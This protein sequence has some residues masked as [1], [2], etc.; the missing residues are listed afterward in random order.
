MKN[1]CVRL[2]C[3][4]LAAGMLTTVSFAAE[5]AWDGTA[6]TTWYND[7]DAEFIL[8]TEEQLAGLNELIAQGNTFAGKTVKL[9]ADMD[10]AGHDWVVASKDFSG[11]FDGQNH[12]ISHICREDTSYTGGRLGLFAHVENGTVK[13]LTVDGAEFYGYGPYGGVIAGSA[14]G[15]C[16]FENITLKNCRNEM[17]NT[18]SAGIVGL[19]YYDSDYTFRGISIDET[20]TIGSFWGSWDTPSGGLIGYYWANSDVESTILAEDCLIAPV[21]NVYNDVCANYQWYA[22]RYA[23][24]LIGYVQSTQVVDGTT[25]PS[26]SNL[27]CRNVTVR[28]GGWS[29]YRYCEWERNGKASYSQDYKFSR[30]DNNDFDSHVHTEEE[31][32]HNI[33]LP[34]AQLFG[35]T[36][37]VYGRADY[38][39]VTIAISEEL[40]EAKLDGVYYK[41]LEETLAAAGDG[42]E[43]ELVKDIFLSEE[44]SGCVYIPAEKSL[45]LQMNNHTIAHEQEN[46]NTRIILNDGTLHIQNGTLNGDIHSSGH[47]TLTGVTGNCVACEAGTVVIEGGAFSG[48]LSGEGLEIRGGEFAQDPSAFV[49][50]GYQVCTISHEIYSY[51]VKATPASPSGGSSGI[52]NN[53]TEEESQW[54]QET[55]PVSVFADV[56]SHVY[57]ADAVQWAAEEKI[58]DGTSNTTFSPDFH[59]TRAQV[60]TFLWRAAGC[61]VPVG[62][63]IPFADVMEDAY[64]YDAVVWALEEGITDG[65]SNAT[66]SPDAHCT[67]AQIVTFLMRAQ[68]AESVSAYN[69]FV[70]VADDVYYTEAVLWAVENG[71]TNGTS[72][73]TFAPYENCT[74]AEVVTFLYRLLAE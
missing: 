10:M 65:T 20:N 53:R 32:Y 63:T 61:P 12:T 39:G 66:F 6:D 74:R 40:A 27:T 43:I 5:T 71:I 30:E 13:N 3:A 69:P 18:G 51:L 21:L 9:G 68:G 44:R 62:R 31:N 4:V 45:V 28:Y 14:Y 59:C 67:R 29:N 15:T 64:Y 50:D 46:E 37:G 55:S 72:A 48:V 47:L 49:P 25:Y 38:P 58:T 41:T 22:Y 2:L 42:S 56:P 33:L 54:E 36:Q 73:S 26:L 19:A 8:T 52:R 70:D 24:M 1:L 34:F 17:Y 16:V 11:V 57:Y 23:G 7:A 35:G 60:V